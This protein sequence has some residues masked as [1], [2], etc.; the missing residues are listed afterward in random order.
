MQNELKDYRDRLEELVEERTKELERE[1]SAHRKTEGEL[2]I[3]EEQYHDIF[4]DIPIAIMEMDYS[5]AYKYLR[6]LKSLGIS[7]LESYFESRP[8]E[9][10]RIFS[11]EKL[12][13]VNKQALRMSEVNK[14]DVTGAI[15]DSFV[16]TI[17]SEYIEQSAKD[18]ILFIFNKYVLKCKTM[19]NE[20]EVEHKI[21]TQKGNIKYLFVKIAFFTGGSSNTLRGLVYHIDITKAKQAEEDINNLLLKER[22]LSE[23]LRQE[24]ERR[25]YLIRALVHELKTPLT[26]LLASTELLIAES[27]QE[28]LLS[29]SKE[30]YSGA[31]LLNKR[32]DELFDISKGEIGALKLKYASFNPVLM[33]QE[34]ANYMKA[35]FFREGKSLDLELAENLPV[36]QADKERLKQIILNLLDNALKF[37]PKEAIITLKA[38]RDDS[39]IKFEVQ[40]TGFGIS[41]NRRQN[42]FKANLKYRSKAQKHSGLGLGLILCKTL[43]ELHG[44]H[45]WVESEYGSGSTFIFTVPIKKQVVKVNPKK[46]R[47]LL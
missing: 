47:L 44:G 40:D 16:E 33:L 14:S 22:Q 11:L 29:L 18:V 10:K 21:I 1:I 17:W 4:N 12:T 19:E 28:P 23:Q 30:A 24:L 32:I 20:Y 8:D 46:Q 34:V 25:V 36:I 6:E 5:A 27:R 9:I 43:V 37:T 26:P 38:K 2:K 31:S 15:M 45:I 42:L 3:S 13:K 7:N 39:Y 35:G 41:D